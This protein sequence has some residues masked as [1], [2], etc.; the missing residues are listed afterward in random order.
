MSETHPRCPLCGAPASRTSDNAWRPFCSE[1]CQ[2][3]DLSRWL[4]GDY[5]I[6]GEQ[7]PETTPSPEDG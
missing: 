2:L 1:R 7:L 6:P 3:R 4:D 5:A